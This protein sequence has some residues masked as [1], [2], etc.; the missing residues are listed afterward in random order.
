M[1]RCG[2]ARVRW[3]RVT[4]EALVWEEAYL[5]LRGTLG[6][7]TDEA[8]PKLP[9][10]ENLPPPAVPPPSD[11]SQSHPKRKADDVDGDADMHNGSGE[12][13]KRTRTVAEASDASPAPAAGAAG[14][15]ALSVVATYISL[16]DPE[17]L[18]PPKMPTREEM[19]GVLLQLRKQAL[20]EEYFGD[21]K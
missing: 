14:D 20:V 8:V 7:T 15:A 17:A 11:G 4:N 18:L 9:R 21:E 5:T 3:G 10:S 6:L 19:E 1:V 12:P 16:L 2:H 13:L